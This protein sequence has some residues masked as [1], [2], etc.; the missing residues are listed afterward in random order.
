MTEAQADRILKELRTIKVCVIIL[1]VI[2][3]LRRPRRLST[4]NALLPVSRAAEADSSLG[5][6]EGL[7]QFS[8]PLLLT[9][10]F[11]ASGQ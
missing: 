10:R 3:P 6:P 5:P 8:G 9:P 4:F 1:T 7:F 2:S 11:R